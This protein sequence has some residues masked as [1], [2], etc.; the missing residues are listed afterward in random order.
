[1]IVENVLYLFFVGVLIVAVYTIIWPDRT[2]AFRKRMGWHNE[3]Q[4]TGGIFYATPA[5]A[6]FMGCLLTVILTPVIVLKIV[7]LLR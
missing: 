4:L 6:R 5:R 1:M 3:S 2:V 7:D